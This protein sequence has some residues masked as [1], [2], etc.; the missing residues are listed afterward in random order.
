MDDKNFGE[1]LTSLKCMQF[2]FLSGESNFLISRQLNEEFA[3]S[4]RNLASY[5]N[6]DV[7]LG[8]RKKLRRHK[9]ISSPLFSSLTKHVPFTPPE[10]VKT[11][12]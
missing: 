11:I 8:L 10:T 1:L 7:V 5:T 12:E 4:Y 3:G 2:D 9:N 6:K